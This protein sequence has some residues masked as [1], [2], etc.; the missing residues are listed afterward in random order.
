M[1]DLLCIERPAPPPKPAPYQA[2]K[3]KSPPPIAGKTK[4]YPSNH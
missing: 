4:L 1:L 2:E 3:G